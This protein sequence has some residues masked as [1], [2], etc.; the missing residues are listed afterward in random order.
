MTRFVQIL[1]L[2]FLALASGRS[3]LGDSDKTLPG[4]RAA[5]EFLPLARL[6]SEMQA[7]SDSHIVYKEMKR[8]RRL[9]CSGE[10]SMGQ[11]MSYPSGGTATLYAGKDGAT[12]N[13]ANGKTLTLYAYRNGATWNWPNGQTMT[14]YA[15]RLDATWYWPNGQLLTSYAGRKG[16]SY[17]T[18]DGRT[19]ISSGPLMKTSTGE[20]DMIAFVELLEDLSAEIQDPAIP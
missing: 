10:Y 15:Y 19:A 20:L 1:P 16:A 18:P 11:T 17:Y 7:D 4:C 13:W 2:L 8:I 5:K 12:W 3:A 14:L 6:Y 9:A